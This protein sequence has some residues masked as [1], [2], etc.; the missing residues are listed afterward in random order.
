VKLEIRTKS[1]YDAYLA[2]LT[3]RHREITA[4]PDTDNRKPDALCALAAEYDA[5][6]ELLKHV[7]DQRVAHERI[8]RG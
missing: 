4:M 3:A 2:D 1:E 5:L 8:A 6:S 7:R